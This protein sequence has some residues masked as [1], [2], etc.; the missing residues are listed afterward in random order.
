MAR[1]SDIVMDHY[2][3]PRNAGTMIDPSGVGRAGNP[4]CGDVME[5]SIRIDDGII[6]RAVFRTYGCGA[7][8][9]ASSSLPR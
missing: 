4:S 9:A 6:A 8:I 7:A 2:R 1:Y 5:L 3:A